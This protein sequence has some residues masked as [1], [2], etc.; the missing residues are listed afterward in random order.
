MS[1]HRSF[2]PSDFSLR[3]VPGFLVAYLLLSA[4]CV[5][6]GF[7]MEQLPP[8]WRGTLWGASIGLAA[9]VAWLSLSRR[10]DV[11][12]LPPPSPRVQQMCEDPACRYPSQLFAQAVKAYIDETGAPL[13]ESTAVLRAFTAAR[14]AIHPSSRG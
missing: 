11:S 14:D 9:G 8:F 10:V 12:S 7:F 5:A 13:S 4:A 2:L 3:D 6:A 1:R